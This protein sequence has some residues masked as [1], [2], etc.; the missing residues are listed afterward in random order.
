VSGN[1]LESQPAF[2]VIRNIR[3]A[4]KILQQTQTSSA[5]DLIVIQEEIANRVIGI[6]A[7]QYGLI[8]RRRSRESR[9]K[10]PVD[11]MVYDA[12]LRFYHYEIELTPEAFEKALGRLETGILLQ[13]G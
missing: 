13:G 5:A 10:A 9:K 7:D 1:L 3:S 8:K 6:I 12:V 2:P 4:A 11:P